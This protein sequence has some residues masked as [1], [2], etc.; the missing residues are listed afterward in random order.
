MS[1]HPPQ[2]PTAP[3]AAETAE[4]AEMP[5]R[6]EQLPVLPRRLEGT[7]REKALARIARVYDHDPTASVRSIA[8]Q[9]GRSY[10]GT[11]RLLIEA[12]VTFRGRGGANRGKAAKR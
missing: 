12:G 9:T 7:A 8:E 5:T 10:G 1:D 6:V 11:R 2:E 4:T 3:K